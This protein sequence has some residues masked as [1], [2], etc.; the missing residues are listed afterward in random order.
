MTKLQLSHLLTKLAGIRASCVAM[1]KTFESEIA[2]T[3][4]NSR[5][6]ARNLLHYLG[7]R[8]HDLRDI[9][10]ELSTL[11]LSSLGRMEAN[12]LAGL[13][14][15][16]VAVRALAGKKAAAGPPAAHGVDFVTGPALLN[17]HSNQLLGQ[18]ID[19]KVRIMVTMPSEAGEQYTVIRDLMSAGMDVMR[20]NCAHDDEKVWMGMI[21]NLRRA[22]REVGRPCKILMDLAGPKLR[23]GD[24]GGGL[25]IMRW[26]TDKDRRGEVIEPKRIRIID[27]V[28]GNGETPAGRP[29][30]GAFLPVDDSLLALAEPDDRLDLHLPHG[31]IRELRIVEKED[32]FCW[33]ESQHS[34][35]GETGMRVTLRH[36]H[37][38]KAKGTIGELPCVE[39]PLRLACGD[40]LIVT[41]SVVDDEKNT[42]EPA[43]IP[44]TLP[45][46]FPYV[47]KGHR[48]AFDDGKIDGIVREATA[49]QLVV[50]ITRARPGG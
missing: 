12:T 31:R 6:S 27:S 11:G 7:L 21:G 41:G 14:A 8:Q 49:E 19:R 50:E 4:E 35:Y 48:I 42:G 33:A 36:K 13:D 43:R 29:S 17:E 38:E 40:K 24:P 30:E 26:K 3:R 22:E 16:Q 25:R 34:G 46:V 15:V 28:A 47:K 44:C 39:E 20:I 18:A 10:F 9:Q 37:K 5:E 32:G 2:A 23:T 45:E 1:E